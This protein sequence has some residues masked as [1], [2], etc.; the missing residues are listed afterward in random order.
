LYENREIMGLSVKQ[1][2]VLEYLVLLGKKYKFI[3]V[4]HEQIARDIKMSRENVGLSLKYLVEKGFIS[5]EMV[6]R[7]T[8]YKIIRATRE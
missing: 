1:K 6:D 2:I 8:V 3:V 7:K 5:R 4:S